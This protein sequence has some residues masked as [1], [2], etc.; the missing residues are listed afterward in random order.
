MYQDKS[1]KYFN[2]PRVDLIG[3]IPKNENNKIL[4][5]GAGSGDTLVE[6]KKLKLAKEVVGVELMKLDDS[7][8]KNSEIDRIIFG[9]IETIEL[10]FPGEYFDVIICGDVLEHLLDPA[11]ALKKLHKYLKTD[12]VLI[13]SIPNFREIHNLCKIVI[14]AD[15]KYEDEGIL[16][17]THLRFFCKK[18]IIE[19]LISAKFTPIEIHSGFRL[20]KETGKKKIFDILTFGIFR[21]FLTVQYKIVAQKK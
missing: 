4:E 19:L 11:N 3:L 10:D 12:G 15:F 17:R 9:N 16:D 1:K 2:N 13:T 21:D 18:N 5:V 6:I 20:Y 14:Q 8:Q 7:Q